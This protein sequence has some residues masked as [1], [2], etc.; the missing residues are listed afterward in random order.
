MEI[1][2]FSPILVDPLI[3]ALVAIYQVLYF[4][5]IPGALGFSIIL[6]TVLIKFIM[7][8][9]TAAQINASHEMMK[10]QPLMK[11]LKEKYK[12]DPKRLQQEQMALFKQHGVNPVAGC[13]P[14]LIQ[15]VILVF[16]FYPVIL[17]I[18]SLKAEDTLS[19]INHIIYFDLIKLTHVWDTNFFGVELGATPASLMGSML[20]VAILIPVVT[21]VLQ[22]IQTKMMMPD[23]PDQKENKTNTAPTPDFSQVF[24]KQMLYMIPF[25][26]GFV[27]F[28]FAIGLSLYWNTFTIFGIIQQYKL[29]GLGGMA[30]WVE[31]LRMKTKI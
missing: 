22:F 12:N 10:I 23:L 17:K 9:L 6:L 29:Q 27:S 2:I 24:Q 11:K 30:G 18:V 19:T 5:H 13:L 7:Y 25:I 15:I 1:G 26:I 21:A 28:Q 3:N 14:S 20:I 8:P 31:R 4:L 16:G